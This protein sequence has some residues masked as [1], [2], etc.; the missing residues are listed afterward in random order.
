M[1]VPQNPD[2]EQTLAI[3]GGRLDLG[4]LSECHGAACGL[5][6]RHPGSNGDAFMHLLASLELLKAPAQALADVFIALHDSTARQLEDDQFRLVLWLPADEESLEDRTLALSHWC[7]G[8][9]AALGSSDDLT[10]E[11]LAEDVPGALSDLEQIA[12]AEVGGD[13]DPEEEETALVEI[14]EYIRV[15]TMMIRDELSPRK[16]RDQLQL[17]QG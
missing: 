15:V 13:G 2:F 6:C 8:F 16:P 3:A 17:W 10:L 12:R 4:E 11:T 14:I 9:L 5:L 1:P 7:T